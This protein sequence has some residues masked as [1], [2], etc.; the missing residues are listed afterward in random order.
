LHYYFNYSGAE[1]KVAYPYADGANL[2]DSKPIVKASQLTLLPWD[3]AII[4][5]TVGDTMPLTLVH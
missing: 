3:L 2:L 4:E 5:E 1:V